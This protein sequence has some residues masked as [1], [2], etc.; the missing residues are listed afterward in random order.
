ME[1]LVKIDDKE[2]E[3]A[4][5]NNM[6]NLNG[7]QVSEITL[8]AMEEYLKNP[9]VMERLIF[10]SSSYSYERNQPTD[11][12][13]NMLMKYDGKSLSD[14][15]ELIIK[16]FNEHYPDLLLEAMKQAFSAQLMSQDFS[17]QLKETL[18]IMDA[19]IKNLNQ[20]VFDHN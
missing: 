10:K 16:Y 8:K 11:L 3:L 13:K 18:S 9:N 2:L 20:K 17:I 19:Q 4:I 7:D 5:L 14:L 6:K 1:L 12:I 15:Q